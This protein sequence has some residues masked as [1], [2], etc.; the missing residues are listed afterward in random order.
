MDGTV[1]L[2]LEETVAVFERTLADP[3]VALGQALETVSERRNQ[4]NLSRRSRS[5]IVHTSTPNI[6]SRDQT[7]FTLVQQQ[8]PIPPRPRSV[9]PGPA[10]S[11]AAPPRPPTPRS[12]PPFQIYCEEQPAQRPINP[13]VIVDTPST[14]FSNNNQENWEPHFIFPDLNSINN[15]AGGEDIDESS[16]L[17]TKDSEP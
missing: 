15:M 11:R 10:P 8:T 6:S 12:A 1:S 17:M 4:I 13:I 9:T 2:N 5:V 7:F 3:Q 16:D 14:A